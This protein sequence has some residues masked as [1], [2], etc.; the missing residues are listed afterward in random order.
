MS[1]SP[2]EISKIRIVD[3]E[4]NPFFKVAEK[5]LLKKRKGSTTLKL[6][7]VPFSGAEPRK[8]QRVDRFDEELSRH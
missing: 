7:A 3:K 6:K 2:E 8:R 4:G 1:L 5:K